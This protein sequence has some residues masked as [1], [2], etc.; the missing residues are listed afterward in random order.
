MDCPHKYFSPN[1]AVIASARMLELVATG[2]HFCDGAF[3]C[4]I[5]INSLGLQLVWATLP[6]RQEQLSIVFGKDKALLYKTT[7]G[8]GDVLWMPFGMLAMEI[9][10]TSSPLI[11][12]F[13]NRGVRVLMPILRRRQRS[14]TCLVWIHFVL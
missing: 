3:R 1:R 7:I 11:C 5:V 14:F 6:S 12:W 9:V 2:F 10:M 8:A 13:R 4:N